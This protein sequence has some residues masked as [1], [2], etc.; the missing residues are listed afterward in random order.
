M[1]FVGKLLKSE[2]LT[3]FAALLYQGC[4][5]LHQWCTGAVAKWGLW[6]ATLHSA[7]FIVQI[8][9]PF[10]HW[11]FEWIL[12]LSIFHWILCILVQFKEQWV[13]LQTFFCIMW[14]NRLI[15][16]SRTTKFYT[17]NVMYNNYKQQYAAFCLLFTNKLNMILRVYKLTICDQMENFRHLL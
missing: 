7:F 4:V 5:A 12:N 3:W 6:W 8:K 14:T 1:F 2:V 13:W 15:R 17:V 10:V 9:V 16:P 11:E